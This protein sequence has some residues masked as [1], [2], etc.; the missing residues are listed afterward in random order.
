[1]PEPSEDGL[2]AEWRRWIVESLCRGCPPDEI[3]R[4]LVADGVP[5]LLAVREINIL[6][7]GA[8]PL[9]QRSRR[10][11]LM[12]RVLRELAT[13]A[14]ILGEACDADEFRARYFS[15]F[16]PA[17]FRGGCAEL[18]APWTFAALRRRFAEVEIAIGARRMTVAAAIDAMLAPAC[19]PDFY[20]TSHDRAL[21]GPLRAMRDELAP[22]PAFLAGDQARE[23]ANLWMGPA[24]TTSPLHHDT[25]CVWFCQLAGAKRYRL[26][27]PWHAAALDA[28]IVR[29]WDS[30]LDLASAGDTVVR[31]LVLEPGDA[32]Y[33]PTGW[34]HEVVALAP[35]ISVSM[36]AFRWPTEHSW[37]APGA[38]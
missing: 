17:V 15:V 13:D 33:I 19:P 28:A 2:D 26:V 1:M 9:V 4:A 7:D 8:A 32:L 3:A 20:V 34:W 16:R 29:S 18:A 10:A 35:S 12:E 30:Q 31:E 11:A 37:Y 23:T 25:T 5:E 38:L 6:V 21:A 36:R 22:L 27:A 14:P 24:G